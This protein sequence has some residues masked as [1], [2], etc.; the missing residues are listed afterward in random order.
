MS[1]RWNSSTLKPPS[2]E[3]QQR[4]TCLQAQSAGI[5]AVAFQSW[6]FLRNCTCAGIPCCW[7]S[8]GFG[9]TKCAGIPVGLKMTSLSSNLQTDLFTKAD[10]STQGKKNS[11]DRP[12]PLQ[13][14][15]NR[16]PMVHPAT[17]TIQALLVR[18]RTIGSFRI[19][20]G[21]SLETSPILSPEM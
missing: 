12:T 1:N 19:H 7:N 17:L 4:S 6:S 5:P 14:H 13:L 21:E 10:N 9:N 11:N 8:S 15:N 20:Q 2:L 18:G 16:G 3:F